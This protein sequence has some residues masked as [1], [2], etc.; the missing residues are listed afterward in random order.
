MEMLD[1]PT[2][3]NQEQLIERLRISLE[4]T[5]KQRKEYEAAGDKEMANY[6]EGWEHAVTFV[7]VNT[8]RKWWEET[9]KSV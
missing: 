3:L 7:L 1:E 8:D 5:R 4:N 6:C 2:F 9:L